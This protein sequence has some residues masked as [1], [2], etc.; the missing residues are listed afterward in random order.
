[1]LEKLGY[2]AY[3]LVQGLVADSVVSVEG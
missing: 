2:Q 3:A 1:M